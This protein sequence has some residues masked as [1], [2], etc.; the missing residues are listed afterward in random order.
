MSA[1]TCPSHDVLLVDSYGGLVCEK[2]YREHAVKNGCRC[3]GTLI[4]PACSGAGLD[5]ATREPKC[6]PECSTLCPVCIPD[7]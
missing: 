2:C 3:D 5:P 4:C 6:S 1:E 7:D